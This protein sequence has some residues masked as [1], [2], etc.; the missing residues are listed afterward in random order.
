VTYIGRAVPVGI[1][2]T[3]QGLFSGTAFS[4]GTICGGAIGGQLAG[5][6]TIR[7]LFAV[8]AVGTAIA[9]ALIWWAIVPAHR[10]AGLGSSVE[11]AGEEAST[12][13]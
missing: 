3:A 10:W 9:A 1:Q 13:A 4:L 11:Q 8:A 6:L 5:V 7:G 12:V 2:G